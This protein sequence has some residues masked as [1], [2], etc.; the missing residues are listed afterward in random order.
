MEQGLW[1]K[2]LQV[3]SGGVRGA[4]QRHGLLTKHERLLRLEKVTAER[5]IELSD[6]QIRLFERFSPEF[7]ERHI[8]APHTDSL[9]AVDT[10][11]VGTLKGVGKIYL[12]STIDCHSRHAWARL[13]TSKL[14][15]TAVHIMNNDVLPTFE[16]A[17]A[18]IEVVLSDIGRCRPLSFL[19][20]R[21]DRRPAPVWQRRLRSGS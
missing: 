14:P 21:S 13:Y 9:V 2:V 19:D 3:S 6:E 10:F 4:W 1:L 18:K 11:F 8:E 20:N 16:A 7:R 5:K 12:Q 15:I 17:G